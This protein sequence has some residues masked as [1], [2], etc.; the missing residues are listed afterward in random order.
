MLGYNPIWIKEVCKKILK[1]KTLE[2]NIK[3]NIIKYLGG[4]REQTGSEKY[5]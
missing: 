5:F 4:V 3:V 2:D 1:H